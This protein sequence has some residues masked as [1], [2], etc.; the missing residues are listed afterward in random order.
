MVRGNSSCGAMKFREKLV[1]SRAGI[2]KSLKNVK[3]TD[4]RSKNYDV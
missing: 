1:E 3:K 4:D 2:K